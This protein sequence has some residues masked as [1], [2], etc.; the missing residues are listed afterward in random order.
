[1]TLGEFFRVGLRVNIMFKRPGNGFNGKLSQVF[2]PIITAPPT[3]FMRNHLSSFL[4]RQ[5]SSPFTPT[6]LLSE[7]AATMYSIRAAGLSPIYY[8]ET[9][10]SICPAVSAVTTTHLNSPK[11][12]SSMLNRHTRQTYNCFFLELCRTTIVREVI[13]SHS[14]H[15]PNHPYLG[16]TGISQC[17]IT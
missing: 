14:S 17:R 13:A 3:V 7:I 2:L 12:Y 11:K 10:I 15:V 1:M 4:R 5:G 16:N 9:S 6:I 8:R